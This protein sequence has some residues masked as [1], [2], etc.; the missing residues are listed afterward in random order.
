MTPKEIGAKFIIPLAI[1]Y[2]E[3]YGH[4]SHL[5]SS[6]ASVEGLAAS[7]G[8][9]RMMMGK[10]GQENV[11]DIWDQSVGKKVFSAVTEP[12]HI[13]NCASGNWA[14]PLIDSYIA[15]KDSAIQHLVANC[16]GAMQVSEANLFR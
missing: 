14:E 10:H 9:L 13:I 11:L 3:A 12:L 5:K 4:R 8:N 16:G 6:R 2:I 15:Q 1:G 7:L